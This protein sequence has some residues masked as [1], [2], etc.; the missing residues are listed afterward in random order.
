MPEIF[1][2]KSSSVMAK[3]PSPEVLMTASAPLSGGVAKAIIGLS[4]FE[5]IIE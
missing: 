2:E 4:I 1:L 5:M 3:T